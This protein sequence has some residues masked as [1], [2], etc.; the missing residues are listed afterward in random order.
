MSKR[1]T[2]VSQ[3][4][5]GGRNIGA[6]L[7]AAFGT[8]YFQ[9]LYVGYAGQFDGSSTIGYLINC[10]L[11]RQPCSLAAAGTQDKDNDSASGQRHN[12]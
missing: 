9:P 12:A 6:W 11:Y 7:T 1:A 10:M 2:S 3:F 8:I 5:L 4:V